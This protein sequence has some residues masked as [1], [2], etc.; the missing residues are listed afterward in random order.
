MADYKSQPTEAQLEILQLLWQHQ[1]CTV[2]FLHEQI[3]TRRELGYTTI[4]KQV[5]RMQDDGLLKRSKGPGKSYVY[6]AVEPAAQTRDKVLNRV[7][8][9][10][11]GD[12]VSEMMLHALGNGEISAEEIDQIKE[13]L[14]KLDR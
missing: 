12:S 10:A 13:L 4:L 14:D 1:P 6:E 3:S 7:V 9:N 11:F 2:R 5:Q 8:K